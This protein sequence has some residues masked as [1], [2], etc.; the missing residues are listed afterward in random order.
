[1]HLETERLLIRRWTHDDVERLLDIQSRPEVVKWLGDGEPVLMKDLDE[2]HQRVE[3][4]DARC[5]Q[6]A[7]Y[8]F[9]AVEVRETGV[10]AGSVLL[11]V[12]PHAE[13]GEVEIGWHLHPDSWGHGY[14]SEA[15]RAI[16]GHGFA[17]GLPEILAVSHTDNHPSQ[18]VMRRIGMTDRGIVE[19]WYD[20]PSAL[21]GLTAAEWADRQ[22]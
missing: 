12:L 4:Y 1:M 20:G 6:G 14:A 10:V 2:A 5:A 17:H 8:G 9:W 21:Y 7:P 22:S 13:A 3:G 16:L 18:A 19:K 11:L 15:A